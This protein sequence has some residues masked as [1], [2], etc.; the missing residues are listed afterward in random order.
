MALN[1]RRPFPHSD[2]LCLGYTGDFCHRHLL[3][4]LFMAHLQHEVDVWRKK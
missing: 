3:I 4:C 1:Y 2:D